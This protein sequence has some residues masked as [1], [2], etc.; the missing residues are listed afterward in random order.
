MLAEYGYYEFD[1][2]L[3]PMPSFDTISMMSRFNIDQELRGRSADAAREIAEA[4]VNTGGWAIYGAAEFI[5]AYLPDQSGSGLHE[6]LY[7]ERLKYLRGLNL[8]HV[9]QYLSPNDMRRWNRLYPGE[10]D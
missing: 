2:Q 1:S 6:Q 5:D 10:F 8:P 4:A 3:A 9:R 7:E